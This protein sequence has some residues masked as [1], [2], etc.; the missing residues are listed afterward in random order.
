MEKNMEKNIEKLNLPTP[1]FFFY[2]QE[3]SRRFI[4]TEGRGEG[5]LAGHSGISDRL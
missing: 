1:I 3:D 2:K 4:D 5:A